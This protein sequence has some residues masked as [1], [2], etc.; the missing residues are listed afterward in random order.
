MEIAAAIMVHT[1]ITRTSGLQQELVAKANHS[2]QAAVEF[3]R[4]YYE[5]ALA[6]IKKAEPGNSALYGEARNV[7][8]AQGA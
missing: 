2:P 5:A 1:I 8:R 3:L 4:P 6:T 7:K